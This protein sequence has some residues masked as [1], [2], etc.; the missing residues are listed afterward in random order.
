MTTK[1]KPGRAKSRAARRA[2][3]VATARA[4]LV[5]G[6]D[7]NSAFALG[8]GAIQGAFF[9]AEHFEKAASEYLERGS[10]EP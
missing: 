1:R 3:V 6:Y 9:L 7:P 8:S 4:L 2:R 5:A 10:A